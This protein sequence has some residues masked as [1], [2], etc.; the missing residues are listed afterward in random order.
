MNGFMGDNNQDEMT[1][2][3]FCL[4]AHP[5][6]RYD[7]F[8]GDAFGM[9]SESESFRRAMRTWTTGVAVLMAAHAGEEYG[10]TINSFTSLALEPP[11]VT[12]VL[13][14]STRIFDLVRKSHVFTITILSAS[15]QE[16]AERFA[17]TLHGAERMAGI[18]TQTLIS[19]APAL[20]NGLA[21]LDCH[22]L[23][24]HAAGGNTLFIAE[25]TEARVDSTDDPLIYHDRRYHGLK[26]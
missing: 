24:T 10:M 8:N 23:H 17:G 4:D 18:H 1:V 20:E 6:L 16:T 9:R 7:D 26:A 2:S 19:G 15:Q 5:P 3:R 14:H 12:V 21:W 22:V 25:I 13:N 11:L